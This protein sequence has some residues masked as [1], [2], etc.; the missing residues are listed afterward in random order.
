MDKKSGFL[1]Y[2]QFFTQSLFDS[3]LN[4]QEEPKIDESI[5]N[6]LNTEDQELLKSQTLDEFLVDS[7]LS[8]IQLEIDELIENDMNLENQKVTNFSPEIFILVEEENADDKNDTSE[9]KN[10]VVKIEKLATPELLNIVSRDFSTEYKSEKIALSK[11][12]CI[13]GEGWWICDLCKDRK[14]NFQFELINHFKADHSQ[15]SAVENKLILT[16]KD[17]FDKEI[18]FHKNGW[19]CSHC[20]SPEKFEHKFQMVTHWQE[21]HSQG[22][23]YDVCQWCNEL[24]IQSDF[25]IHSQ[26]VHKSLQ[27][28]HYKCPSCRYS[29]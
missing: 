20:D 14:F 25:F 18:Y 21:N 28:R 3:N 10:N 11:D 5:E 8:D 6:D 2:G 9:P 16:A 7:N 22:V 23:T 17:I 1:P 15:V 19:S 26:K 24:F 13:D 4:E 27:T 12:E 29:L